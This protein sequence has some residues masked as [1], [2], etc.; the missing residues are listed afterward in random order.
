MLGRRNVLKTL[1]LGGAA[2]LAGSAFPVRMA[3]AAAATDQRFVFVI[4]RGAA[5]GLHIVPPLGDPGYAPLRGR[6]LGS[7][8][9]AHKID[10][11]F[12]LHP[13]LTR[14]A[15]MFGQHQAMAIHAVA[16]AYRDRSHFD[17]QNVLETGGRG[18]YSE[19]DGWLNRLLAALPSAEARAL[20][21]APDIPMA[22]RGSR[23]VA[24]YAPSTLPEA[25][26]D[27]L[28]R[29]SSLYAGDAQLA[30]LWRSALDT[31]RV[32]EGADQSAT[33]NSGAVIGALAA[34]LLRPADGARVLM[35]ETSGWDTH[36]SQA[37]RLKTRLRSLD[38]LIG[39]LADGLGPAWNSTMVLVATEFGRTAAVNGTDG[40]DHGTASAALL[41]GGAL[42]GGGTV[43]ADWPGLGQNALYEARD[44]RPT[45][46][47]EGVITG[48]LARHYALDPARLAAMLY[49]EQAGLKPVLV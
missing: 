45:L 10:G 48:A 46:P 12:S 9:S 27:L 8:Q 29:V 34:R 13:A 36:S 43:H 18:P 7:L 37:L 47:L 11:T 21:L 28:Q 17:G 42:R 25:T 41:L 23:A 49:P 31:R 3:F 19:P 5:D 30:S 33:G 32:A 15:S 22:L 44:L 35:I 20:A 24:S 26:E 39:A 14:T 38:D 16:S 4:Q 2:G 6:L 1:A 40:T